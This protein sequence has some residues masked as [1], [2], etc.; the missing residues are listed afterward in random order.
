ATGIFIILRGPGRTIGLH[1]GLERPQP[2]SQSAH[3]RRLGQARSAL[4]RLEGVEELRRRCR[5]CPAPE[6]TVTEVE[7][8]LGGSSGSAADAACRTGYPSTEQMS[9]KSSRNV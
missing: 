9:R 6:R 1:G 4:D 5:P 3:A 2:G 8:D 7:H